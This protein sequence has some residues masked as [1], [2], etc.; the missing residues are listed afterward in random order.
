MTVKASHY[1]SAA[2]IVHPAF[3][4][5]SDAELVSCPLALIDS[6]D[7]PKDTMDAFIAAVESKVGEDKVFRKR[8]DTFHGFCAGRANYGDEKNARQ[9]KEAYTDL[10]GFFQKFLA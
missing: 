2:A 1:V 9:A 7:E 6:T 8:Y 10:C 5:V 3:T 4:Q